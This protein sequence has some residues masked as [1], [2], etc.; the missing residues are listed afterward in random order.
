VIEETGGT[1]EGWGE[2]GNAW[3]KSVGDGIEPGVGDRGHLE[4]GGREEGKEG[5]KEGGARSCR[6][7]QKT[8]TEGLYEA[9]REQLLCQAERVQAGGTERGESGREGG[10]EGERGNAC[11]RVT[12]EVTMNPLSATCCPFLL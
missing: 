9:V 4:E 5:R 11:I 7:V 2:G 10:R 12:G 8:M 6:E 3:E 1:R